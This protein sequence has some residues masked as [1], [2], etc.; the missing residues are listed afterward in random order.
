VAKLPLL[1]GKASGQQHQCELDSFSTMPFRRSAAS[2]SHTSA[3]FE[4][5]FEFHV[6][7]FC[8]FPTA[9]GGVLFV[10]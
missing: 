10:L 3:V 4:L 7:G 5:L 9:R 2:L 1:L 8:R 6:F